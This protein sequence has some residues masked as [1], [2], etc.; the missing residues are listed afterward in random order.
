MNEI[1]GRVA[2][3]TRFPVKSMAGEALDSARL[4]WSGLE[5]DRQYAFLLAG[6]LSRFPWFT[7]RDLSELVCWQARYLDPADTRHSPVEVIAPDGERHLL[8]SLELRWL[9]G[10][11]AEAGIELI[12]LGRGAFDAQPVSIVPTG[13]FGAIAAARAEAVDPRRFR[14]SAAREDQELARQTGGPGGGFADRR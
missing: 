1:V 5:G 10:E 6:S 12:Q 2:G 9:L 7:G 11:K 14:L 4:R 13:T 3:L 8:D